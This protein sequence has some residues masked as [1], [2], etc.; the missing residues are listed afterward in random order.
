MKFY[1]WHPDKSKFS[2]KEIIDTIELMEN[3]GFYPVNK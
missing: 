1:D 2:K 3:E